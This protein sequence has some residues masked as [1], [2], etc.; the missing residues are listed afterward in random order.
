MIN[1][2]LKVADL[3]GLST[4]MLVEAFKN[5]YKIE[6]SLNIE[7]TKAKTKDDLNS[8][9]D[10]NLESNLDILNV[11][12]QSLASCPA[13]IVKGTVQ[14]ITINASGGIPPYTVTFLVDG[15]S[16]Y[17]S[18]IAVASGSTSF[19]W[20]FNETTGNHTY[21]AKLVDS[22]PS[23]A[24]T[25]FDTMC[26]INI[27][28]PAPP[29]PPPIPTLGSIILSGC[30]YTISIGESCEPNISC[31]DTTGFSMTCSSLS[32]SSS[33]PAIA[34]VSITGLISGISAGTCTITARSGTIT[35]NPLT[36]TVS[37]PICIPD[38]VCRSPLDGYEHDVK[39]CPGSV[40]RPNSRCNP[41]SPPPPTSV[42]DA[43]T[44]DQT[45]NICLL[46]QC[47]PK[48]Y[49]YAGAGFFGLFA[50]SMLKR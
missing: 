35:S 6:E 5:G 40:D 3:Q 24:Q 29:P 32:W 23:G 14:T 18:T 20:S 38:W 2:V 22:C 43:T 1:K 34:S 9:L 37:V 12:M 19:S 17:S 7:S 41:V 42:C 11:K 45:S 13:S 27:T 31:L 44:C 15:V 50:L 26:T 36:I 49:T 48:L 4:E 30:P 39:N 47:V 10:L 33:N 8:N 46:G 25:A 28:S 16:A 21:Q